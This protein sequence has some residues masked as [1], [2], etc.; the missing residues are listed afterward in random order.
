M[1]KAFLPDFQVMKKMKAKVPKDM[2]L[3]NKIVEMTGLNGIIIIGES[4]EMKKDKPIDGMEIQIMKKEVIIPETIGIEIETHI[5]EEVKNQRETL[6]G[7][8]DLEIE[9]T[10]TEMAK[11]LIGLVEEAEDEA[12]AEILIKEITMIKMEITEIDPGGMT[13][14][15]NK[16]EDSTEI[17]GMM[18]ETMGEGLTVMIG[19]LN[20]ATMERVHSSSKELEKWTWT[21]IIDD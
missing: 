16:E 9:T 15:D 3:M 11:I 20:K 17:I 14:S 13:I 10:M 6:I 4:P 21:W 8:M 1:R 12:E 19:K 5:I 7:E 18:I 2:F